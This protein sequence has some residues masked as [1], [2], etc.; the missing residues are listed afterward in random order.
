LTE[1]F[2]LEYSYGLNIGTEISFLTEY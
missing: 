2:V 1:Y